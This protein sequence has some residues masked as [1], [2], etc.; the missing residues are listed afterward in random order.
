VINALTI[1]LMGVI[2]EQVEKDKHLGCTIGKTTPARPSDYRGN[3]RLQQA[4][5]NASGAFP[6][7]LPRSQVQPLQGLI[8]DLMS[9]KS[10]LLLGF[11]RD[12]QSLNELTEMIDI[13]I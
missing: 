1:Q 4:R 11:S 12:R 8:R 5:G 2:I 9:F 13:M 7:G 3:S 6:V 10:H